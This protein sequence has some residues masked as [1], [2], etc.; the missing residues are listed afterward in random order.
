MAL[1]YIISI[2][3]HAILR[4]RMVGGGGV[5]GLDKLWSKYKS[6]DKLSNGAKIGEWLACYIEKGGFRAFKT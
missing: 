3:I 4:G 5:G 6:G 1:N 2:H